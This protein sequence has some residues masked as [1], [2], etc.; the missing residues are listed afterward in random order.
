MVVYQP[1][2]FHYV[3]FDRTTSLSVNQ[4][5]DVRTLFK[6]SDYRDQ[7]DLGLYALCGLEPYK[8]YQICAL[9]VENIFQRH[10]KIENNRVIL[11]KPTF[12]H[13]LKRKNEYVVILPS[14]ISEE[15]EIKINEEIVRLKLKTEKEIL[16]LKLSE[17]DNKRDVYRK[18]KRLFGM[19][20]FKGVLEMMIE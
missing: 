20:E 14:R 6:I 2:T 19:I 10:L 3:D 13:A 5:L 15:L 12:I 8:I 11:N 9:K 16:N 7:I 18:I 17:C 4:Q 1:K